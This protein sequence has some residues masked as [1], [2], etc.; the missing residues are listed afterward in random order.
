MKVFLI[1]AAGGVGTSLARLLTSWGDQVT[2]MHRLSLQAHTVFTAGATPLQGDLATDSVTDLAA[3]MIGHDAVVFIAG[4]HDPSLERT[5]LIDGKGLKNAAEAATLA[6]A[7]RFVLVLA[8]PESERGCFVS[9]DVEH[10]LAVKQQAEV[11]L[12]HTALEWLIVRP[13]TLTH[14]PGTGHVTAAVAT[15]YGPVSMDSQAAFIAQA[16]HERGLRRIIVEV[17]DGHTPISEAA[18][19]PTTTTTTAP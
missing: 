15:A 7:N 19:T 17:V 18:T 2:G 16:L 8:F 6:G 5:T 4:A 9:E 10:Y 12:A 3:K 11:H 13:G 14:A 1:G